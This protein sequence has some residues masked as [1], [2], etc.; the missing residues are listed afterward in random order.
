MRTEVSID[1]ETLSWLQASPVGHVSFEQAVRIAWEHIQANRELG[2]YPLFLIPTEI[3]LHREAR[4]E[5]I[6]FFRHEQPHCVPDGVCVRVDAL[7]GAPNWVM[8][9]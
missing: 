4:P 2:D 9:E 7:T 1:A 3:S 8:L 6:V 5:W